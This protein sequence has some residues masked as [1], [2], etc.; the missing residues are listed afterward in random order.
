MA[1]AAIAGD[2]AELTISG[3]TFLANNARA[4]NGLPGSAGLQRNPGDPGRNGGDAAGGAVYWTG[5]LRVTNSTF[6]GNAVT[7]GKLN[8]QRNGIDNIQWLCAPVPRAAAQFKKQRQ[9][10]SKIVL[11]PPR[12]GAKGIEADIASLGAAAILYVSCNPATLARDLAALSRHGYKLASVQPIDFFP[13]TFH[14]E[15]LAVMTR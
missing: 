1:G 6:Y 11:D 10:F 15:S 5:A 12:G 4:T 8:G 3:C 14:V 7:S 13:H 9:N 2:K